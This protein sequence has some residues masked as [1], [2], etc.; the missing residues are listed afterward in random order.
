MT[1]VKAQ[2]ADAE[3]PIEDR[4]MHKALEHEVRRQSLQMAGEREEMAKCQPKPNISRKA[5]ELQRPGDVAD[6]LFEYGRVRDARREKMQERDQEDQM[7]QFKPVPQIT[8]R[9]KNMNRDVKTL[10]SWDESRRAKLERAREE[11]ETVKK[12]A[13]QA[14]P[15]ISRN[16]ERLVKNMNRTRSIGDHLHAQAQVT[17]RRKEQLQQQKAKQEQHAHIPAISVHSA[18]LHREGKVGDRLYNEW[19]EKEEK[20]RESHFD[21]VEEEPSHRPKINDKSRKLKTKQKVHERLYQ[22]GEE[23]KRKREEM[24]EEQLRQETTQTNRVTA[25]GTKNM[26]SYSALLVDLMERRTNT[27]TSERLQR[28]TRQLKQSTLQ[29]LEEEEMNCTFKPHIN[30][31]S[32]NI[33]QQANQEVL[34]PGQS[35]IDLMFQRAE[36]YEFR[37]ARMQEAYLKQ[38]MSQCTFSPDVHVDSKPAGHRTGNVVQRSME[39][40]R[41]RDTN[42]EANKKIADEREMEEVGRIGRSTSHA[43]RPK[44]PGGTSSRGSGSG[45]TS[46]R[47]SP[48]GRAPARPQSAPGVRRPIEAWADAGYA[49]EYDDGYDEYGEYDDEYYGDEGM[50]PGA[51]SVGRLSPGSPYEGDDLDAEAEDWLHRVVGAAQETLNQ[52]DNHE[53]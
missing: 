42:R 26:G 3:N 7:A 48:G 19:K 8:K 23:Y 29:D 52:G 31:K 18:S 30:R 28:P 38:E 15:R 21:E 25:S 17:E 27:T 39:W 44:T 11:K 1:V 13:V 51:D 9:A 41:R 36:E 20:K 33:D 47:V 53:R 32:R 16:S 45:G 6:R 40:L 10:Q 49:G 2:G 50:S 22:K 37:R 43:S 35:R 5:K 34:A 46:T 24:A 4:L 14:G 12:A